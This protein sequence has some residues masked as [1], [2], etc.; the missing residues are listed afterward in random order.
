[1]VTTVTDRETPTSC[2]SSEISCQKAL[3][4]N[5]TETGLGYRRRRKQTRRKEVHVRREP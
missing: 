5:Q 3:V 4:H 2:V 1:M